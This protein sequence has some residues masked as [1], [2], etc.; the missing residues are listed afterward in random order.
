[1]RGSSIR[2]I[3]GSGSP[4]WASS[5]RAQGS[6]CLYPQVGLRLAREPFETWISRRF[7][8]LLT[9]VFM[10]LS[11]LARSGSI[12]G[13]GASP[14]ARGRSTVFAAGPTQQQFVIT[15]LQQGLRAVDNSR[16]MIRTCL[17]FL[18]TGC[19]LLHPAEPAGAAAGHVGQ[20]LLRGEQ[21]QQL[22]SVAPHGRIIEA[23]LG[24][25]PA[26]SADQ[27]ARCMHAWSSII[28]PRGLLRCRAVCSRQAHTAVSTANC[29]G[30]SFQADLNFLR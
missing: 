27:T 21:F 25:Q 26:Q 22:A 12:T 28:Q 18:L 30:L 2:L 29:R 6:P 4:N 9:P 8:W 3:T 19:G 15:A 16:A 1:M 17:E 10:R 5:T 14:S 20:L 11:P 23:Y 7:T 24:F 13:Q